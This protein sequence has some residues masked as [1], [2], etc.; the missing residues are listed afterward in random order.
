M[1]ITTNL[2]DTID[3]YHLRQIYISHS[4]ELITACIFIT[5]LVVVNL[6]LKWIFYYIADDF[7]C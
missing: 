3:E 4:K 1:E 7:S 2:I 5:C 6:E